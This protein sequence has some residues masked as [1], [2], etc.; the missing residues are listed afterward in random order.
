MEAVVKPPNAPTLRVQ[1]PPPLVQAPI[2]RAPPPPPPLSPGAKGKPL[3][4]TIPTAT[5]M[6]YQQAMAATASA[7]AQPDPSRGGG[8]HTRQ[9]PAGLK[10][11]V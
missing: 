6:P 2:G 5:V 10:A 9:E 1:A 8:A 4:S 11:A 7:N 3:A